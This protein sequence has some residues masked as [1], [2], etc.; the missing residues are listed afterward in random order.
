MPLPE[1]KR[2][3]REQT[4]QGRLSNWEISLKDISNLKTPQTRPLDESRTQESDLWKNTLKSASTSWEI[5]SWLYLNLFT[6]ATSFKVKWS[7]TLM[8]SVPST[9]SFLSF[10]KS[11][12]LLVWLG[13]EARELF[14]I[15]GHV[16]WATRVHEP[17]V[18]QAS[19][20]HLRRMRKDRWLSAGFSE[21]NHRNSALNYATRRDFHSPLHLTIWPSGMWAMMGKMW[22][23]QVSRLKVRARP[24]SRKTGPTRETITTMRTWV[25][26]KASSHKVVLSW[27]KTLWAM[28]RSMRE[29][30]Q[31]TRRSVR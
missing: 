28:V 7:F 14:L 8:I 31:S 1:L 15:T 22:T 20:Q 21:I 6:R 10:L 19:V 5:E 16:S 23:I 2:R 17:L 9:L 13:S 18:L 27:T 11:H 24:S 30:R 4:P 25:V 12:I 26:T 3:Q 29:M